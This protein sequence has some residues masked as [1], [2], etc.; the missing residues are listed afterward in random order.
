MDTIE[1]LTTGSADAFAVNSEFTAGIFRTE[2]PR[3]SGKPEIVYPGISLEAYDKQVGSTDPRCVILETTRKTILS[4]NRFERKK[5]I[6]LAIDAFILFR[7]QKGADAASYRLVLAGGYDPRLRENVEHHSELVAL[8]Q[9]AGLSTATIFPNSTEK[10]EDTD[11]LFLLSFSEAQRTLLLSTAI[12]L[13]YTPSNEHFGIVPIE[14]MYMRVP[15]IACNSGGPKESIVD[16]QTGFLCEATADSFA[17]ALVKIDRLSDNGREQ[18]GLAGRQRVVDNFSVDAM[19]DK[20]DSILR[21][22]DAD[23]KRGGANWIWWLVWPVLV[24]AVVWGLVR[25]Y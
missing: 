9:R 14:A 10:P 8:A 17:E 19:S 23:K 3:I 25:Y 21:E 22:L 11:V 1:D 24:L 20:L 12:C 2:F 18:M 13:V 5:N 7:K 16:G 4:F 6:A 15:V